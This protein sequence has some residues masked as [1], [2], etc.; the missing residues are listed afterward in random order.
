MFG[1]LQPRWGDMVRRV[2]PY[3]PRSV[4]ASFALQRSFL[5]LQQFN[6]L[7]IQPLAN[8]LVPAIFDD[9]QIR[10]SGVRSLFS[11]LP[12]AQVL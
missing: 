6:N 9:D 10:N 7:T 11:P 1:V 4:A 5:T 3:A 12:S 2:T 8:S